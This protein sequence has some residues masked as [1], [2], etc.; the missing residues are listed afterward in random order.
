MGERRERDGV[1]LAVSDEED[2]LEDDEMDECAGEDEWRLAMSSSAALER[3]LLAGE[4]GIQSV[5]E[6]TVHTIRREE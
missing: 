1:A 6:A 3:G 5:M 4:G 2:E